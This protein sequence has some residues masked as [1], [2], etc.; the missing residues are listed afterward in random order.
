MIIADEIREQALAHKNGKLKQTLEDYNLTIN[1]VG[2]F[3]Y[4]EDTQMLEPVEDR[5]YPV[6]LC[7]SVNQEKVT[8]MYFNFEHTKIQS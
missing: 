2:V 6:N 7:Y 1:D 4:D 3:F 5:S 8:G